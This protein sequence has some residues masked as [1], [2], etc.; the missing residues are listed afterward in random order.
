MFEHEYRF[1]QM[2]IKK[3]FFS[4]IQRKIKFN[5]LNCYFCDNW[6]YANMLQGKRK[7]NSLFRLKTGSLNMNNFKQNFLNKLK[8]AVYSTNGFSRLKSSGNLSADCCLYADQADYFAGRR[9]VFA[10]RSQLQPVSH[11][12][13]YI[14]LL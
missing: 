5:L 14:K 3:S 9:C 1:F 13:K 11:F 12:L 4:N 8:S 7:M 10:R 6:I 2:W